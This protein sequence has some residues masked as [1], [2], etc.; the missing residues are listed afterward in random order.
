MKLI[1]TRTQLYANVCS[2]RKVTEFLE[3]E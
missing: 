1:K 2:S 3:Q